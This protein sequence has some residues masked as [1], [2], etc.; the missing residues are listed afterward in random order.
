LTED[1]LKLEKILNDNKNYYKDFSFTLTYDQIKDIYE[2]KIYNLTLEDLK[3]YIY[4][5]DYLYL[6]DRN[7]INLRNGISKEKH[8][9]K[10]ILIDLLYQDIPH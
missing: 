4:V 8:Y 3:R 7:D 2:N 5:K 1:Q 10:N 6:L 9:Y